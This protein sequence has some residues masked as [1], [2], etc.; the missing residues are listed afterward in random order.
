LIASFAA[1][2]FLL[3]R[4]SASAVEDSQTRAIAIEEVCES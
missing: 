3:S 2:P 4:A 1:L